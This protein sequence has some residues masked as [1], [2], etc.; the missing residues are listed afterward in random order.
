MA[1]SARF[2]GTYYVLWMFS[3]S[4][5]RQLPCVSIWNIRIAQSQ[6]ISPT[7]IWATARYKL[8]SAR[9]L[10]SPSVKPRAVAI[11]VSSGANARVGGATQDFFGL[12][13]G[14][15]G[16][17]RPQYSLRFPETSLSLHESL[18]SPLLSSI[19]T[20]LTLAQPH[21]RTHQ[22]AYKGGNRPPRPR[23]TIAQP[24]P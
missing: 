11:G 21:K 7:H 22:S 15:V 14:H 2:G 6:L 17:G 19:P 3:V 5:V 18:L 1:L 12:I 10:I 24:T 9:S 23:A 8:G 16:Q 13:G 4:Y 20:L